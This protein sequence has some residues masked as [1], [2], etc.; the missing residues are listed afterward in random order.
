MT[1][2]QRAFAL[3]LLGLGSCAANVPAGVHVSVTK[4]AVS[5]DANGVVLSTAV[6]C[7]G[8]AFDQFG[9]YGPKLSPD[10]HWALVDVQ[11]PFTPGNVPRTEALVRVVTGE[12]VFAPNFPAYL[13]VPAT[14][15]PISWASGQRATLVYPG[16]K[17]ATIADPPL[18]P[19]P[20]PHCVRG[21]DLRAA[22]PETSPEPSATP[23]QF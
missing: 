9:A 20:A 21:N 15:V 8:F 2:F 1:S 19:I 11:G 13:G 17:S 3:A 22:P 7:P 12:L 16:G 4:E 6:L 5:F 14:L 23:Y 10:N 18:R